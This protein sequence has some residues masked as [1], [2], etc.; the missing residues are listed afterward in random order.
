MKSTGV[1]ALLSAVR[2]LVSI[3]WY[4]LVIGTV[5]YAIVGISVLGSREL[6]IS[7]SLPWVVIQPGYALVFSEAEVSPEGLNLAMRLAFP[8]GIPVIVIYLIML[9]NLRQLLARGIENPFT[10]ENARRIRL[11]GFLM[12]AGVVAD[13]GFNLLLAKFVINYVH[14][15][16]ATIRP[17]PL[18]YR[19]GLFS[20]LLMLVVS[21]VFRLG[22]LLQEEHDLTV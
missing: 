22:V 21:E 20:A 6:S 1:K 10:L 3:G 8:I 12:L 17:N 7:R 11:I 2:V 16:G 5:F 13:M 18:P 14:I 15:P 19:G 4:L 9:R